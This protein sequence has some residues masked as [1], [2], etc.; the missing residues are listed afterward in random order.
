MKKLFFIA[1]ILA[2]AVTCSAS[3][4]ECVKKSAVIDSWESI[5]NMAEPDNSGVTNAV[6]DNC[7]CWYSGSIGSYDYF[8]CLANEAK[9]QEEYFQNQRQLLNRAKEHGICAE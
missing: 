8:E 6:C 9:K 4:K 1:M 5:L 7:A 2:M 3:D